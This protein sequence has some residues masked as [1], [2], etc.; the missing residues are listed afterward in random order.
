MRG[1]G[2][3]GDARHERLAD[4]LAGYNQLLQNLQRDGNDGG[5]TGVERRLQGDDELRNDRKNFLAA[6]LKHVEH[7][8]DCEEAV[9]LFLF[10]QPVKKDGKVVMEI[11]LFDFHLPLDAVAD[12]A[13]LDGN[14]QVA[15][16]VKAA[17]FGVG[18]VVSDK[19]RTRFGYFDGLAFLN[20]C[21]GM[22]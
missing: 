7:T 22:A 2:E 20:A 5:V 14:G 17:E 3:G 15:S 9:G 6:V 12:A 4:E 19:K 16:F 21:T 11:Q 8:L 13:M 1:K 10:P 18:G